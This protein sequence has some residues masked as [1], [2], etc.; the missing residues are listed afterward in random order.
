M[1]SEDGRLLV[2]SS[3]DRTVKVW[4]IEGDKPSLVH[5]QDIKLVSDQKF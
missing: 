3:T 4:D 5:S 1:S 2:T